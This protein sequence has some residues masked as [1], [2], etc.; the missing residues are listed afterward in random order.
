MVV[1]IL[2]TTLVVTMQS[3]IIMIPLGE[4]HIGMMEVLVTITSLQVLMDRLVTSCQKE[5]SE[6]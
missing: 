5:I 4:N 6:F 3:K 2:H 1:H